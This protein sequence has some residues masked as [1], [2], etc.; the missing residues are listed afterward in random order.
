MVFLLILMLISTYSIFEFLDIISQMF[1]FTEKKEKDSAISL[2]KKCKCRLY[3]ILLIIL[4][5]YQVADGN[6]TT[7]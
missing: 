7:G 6:K 2:F 3:T 5:L 1:H 4:L